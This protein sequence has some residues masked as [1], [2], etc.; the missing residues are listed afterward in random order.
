MSASKDRK[1]LLWNW[2]FTIAHAFDDGKN[3]ASV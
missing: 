3:F 2:R 1:V